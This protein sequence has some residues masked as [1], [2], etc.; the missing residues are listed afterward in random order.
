MQLNNNDIIPNIVTTEQHKTETARK[1]IWMNS[2]I[3]YKQIQT[4][5]HHKIYNT[6]D[7]F[8]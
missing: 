7:H 6:K 2:E 1:A 5:A 4:R 3:I 8:F